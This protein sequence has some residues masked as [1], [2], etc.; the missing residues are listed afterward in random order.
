MTKLVLTNEAAK[1]HKENGGKASISGP[2]FSKPTYE[3][4]DYYPVMVE[5]IHLL[6]MTHTV[7]HE[8]EII[9]RIEAM[10]IAN[11]KTV[12]TNRIFWQ[13]T[14]Q[15][16]EMLLDERSLSLYKD[17]FSDYLDENLISNLTNFLEET[18]KQ[19]MTKYLAATEEEKLEYQKINM[20]TLHSN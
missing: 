4:R 19:R 9:N 14:D 10:E 7:H 12:A 17:I 18:N 5:L 16:H 11:P 2:S 20:V 13:F 3:K 8:E 15:G 6:E 1:R